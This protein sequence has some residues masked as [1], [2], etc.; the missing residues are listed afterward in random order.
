MLIAWGACVL[1]AMP[2]M[3]NHLALRGWL[4]RWGL[5]PSTTELAS[6]V[7]VVVPA[8]DEEASIG[9]C[10]DAILAS[11]VDRVVLVDDDSSDATL[12][13]ARRRADPRLTIVSA[14]PRPPG[15][16]GKSWACRCGAAGVGSPWLL[17]VDADVRIDPRTPGTLVQL[18]Q[19]D[20]RD[21]VSV[22]GTWEVASVAERLLVPAFGWLVRSAV[23]MRAVHEGRAAFANGQVILARRETYE[24]AGGHE[25]HRGRVLDDVGLA[26][27]VQAVGGR[28]AVRWAPWAARL[29]PYASGAEVIAGYR[30]N[31]AAG[32]G[33]R[34][35]LA[36]AG[37]AGLALVYLGPAAMVVVAAWL[38][39]T[40]L[41]AAAVVALVLQ[42]SL[43][44]R[45]ELL[46][47]R[48]PWIAALDPL[49]GAVVA[50][51]LFLSAFGG[52]VR[53]KG[54]RFRRGLAEG[55]TDP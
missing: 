3:L 10:L 50:A 49:A 9:A 44:A 34:R 18:G 2:W 40:A 54:R 38:G 1:V 48:P 33:G 47:G 19:A 43:R 30:K 37:V 4:A 42:V 20:G 26:E 12:E 6:G 7:C 17:F 13:V 27:A 5:A 32:L 23:P 31:L 45:L 28:V 39:Q 46:D 25:T 53:W 41:V 36:L 24:R 16:S 35:W 29:R 8:R 15:W 11:D 14:P 55:A 21:L 51:T 52:D 22:F